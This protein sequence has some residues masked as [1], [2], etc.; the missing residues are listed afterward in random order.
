MYYY[1]NQK[2]TKKIQE[3][4]AD[5]SPQITSIVQHVHSGLQTQSKKVQGKHLLSLLSPPSNQKENNPS[6]SYL[7]P[8]WIL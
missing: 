2:Q 1:Y 7:S 3:R 8:L 5:L 6:P 4:Q